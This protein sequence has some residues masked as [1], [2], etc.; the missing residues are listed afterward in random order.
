MG[1]GGGA[2]CVA[3][4]HSLMVFKTLAGLITVQCCS[5]KQLTMVI[6]KWLKYTTRKPNITMA[7]GSVVFFK[8]METNYFVS[9]HTSNTDWGLKYVFF[10]IF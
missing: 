7:S 10:S 3:S 6:I 9:G 1:T 4:A 2:A 8:I 5:P